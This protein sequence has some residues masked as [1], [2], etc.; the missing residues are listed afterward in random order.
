MSTV[1]GQQTTICVYW[2]LITG[3]RTTIGVKGPLGALASIVVRRQ[4]R[5]KNSMPP[6]VLIELAIGRIRTCRIIWRGL[7]V[8][9]LRPSSPPLRSASP[10]WSE[11]HRNRSFRSLKSRK[12]VRI[13]FIVYYFYFIF[14]LVVHE[15][16]VTVM[17]SVLLTI[18]HAAKCVFN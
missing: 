5:F 10:S 7:W 13:P 17:N 18:W 14:I 2:S 11:I 15:G 3:R 12:L 9:L 6:A 4:R 16:A 1:W 8:P